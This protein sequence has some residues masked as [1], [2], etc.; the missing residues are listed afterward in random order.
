MYINNRAIN[1][2]CLMAE[3]GFVASVGVEIELTAKSFKRL[4]GAVLSI[5]ENREDLYFVLWIAANEVIIRDLQRVINRLLPHLRC[6]KKH[7]FILWDELKS[8]QLAAPWSNVY[9]Q[10]TKLFG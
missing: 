3:H 5:D 7:L 4:V 2:M 8:R 10:T 1:L 9:G 6:P